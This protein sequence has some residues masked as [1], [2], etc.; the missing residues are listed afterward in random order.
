MSVKIILT[1]LVFVWIATA[2]GRAMYRHWQE[3][4]L[5]KNPPKRVCFQVRVPADSQ[6]SNQKMAR[7]WERL[8]MILPHDSRNLGKNKNVIRMALIGEGAEVGASPTI[9]FLVWCPPHL[10]GKVQGTLEECYDGAEVV[11]M[12]GEDDPFG[13]YIELFE[14]H[15]AA[16]TPR[17]P[18]TDHDPLVPTAEPVVLEA[19]DHH[20]EAEAPAR[21]GL[22]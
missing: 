15:E 19:P 16:G 3:N 2:I 17:S 7:V 12:L 14:A 22:F 9:R 1:L 8:W 20:T 21:R 6:K 11:E 5:K 4:Q 18:D 13:H 10:V